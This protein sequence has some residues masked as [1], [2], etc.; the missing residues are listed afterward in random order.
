MTDFRFVQNGALWL[1]H[2]LDEDISDRYAQ[3]EPFYEGV[4][5]ARFLNVIDRK[6]YTHEFIAEVEASTGETPLKL[7]IEAIDHYLLHEFNTIV[8]AEWK[9][10]PEEIPVV[11]SSAA[12]L[13]TMVMYMTMKHHKVSAKLAD[14][15]ADKSD[16]EVLMQH[17]QELEGFVIRLD[18]KQK[19]AVL[20]LPAS[21]FV[22]NSEDKEN[23]KATF[24][25]QFALKAE[26]AQLEDKIKALEAEVTQQNDE[27]SDLKSRLHHFETQNSQASMLTPLTTAH[28]DAIANRLEAANR[29]KEK[30]EENLVAKSKELTTLT[31]DYSELESKYNEAN[32]KLKT[33]QESL[34]AAKEESQKL[35]EDL[36]ATRSQV[37]DFN[38]DRER[39]KSLVEA[40]EERTEYL[41]KLEREKAELE[42]KVGELN[43][44]IDEYHDVYA[45]NEQLREELQHYPLSEP[46]SS[47]ASFGNIMPLCDDMM[48]DVAS[49]NGQYVSIAQYEARVMQL[50]HEVQVLNVKLEETKLAHQKVLNQI[51]AATADQI[52]ELNETILKLK[53][54]LA[55][56]YEQMRQFKCQTVGLRTKLHN[57]TSFLGQLVMFMTFM[58]FCFLMYLKLT[59]TPLFS[60]RESMVAHLK[61]FDDATRYFGRR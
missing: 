50:S 9:P 31:S 51:R 21:T 16:A 45:E 13:V 2:V 49:D 6:R 56:C 17:V 35:V 37:K 48:S 22:V 33:L 20:T 47:E 59:N 46:S 61:A 34:K 36:E 26:R 30:L 39:F 3:L 27:V 12:K 11:L 19:A 60:S 4:L 40:L 41:E 28:A 10:H 42:G 44:R 29:C 24:S 43:S 38:A 1:A 25:D 5:L 53:D 18:A 7:I 55:K 14:I 58:L 15:F 57:L 8:S 32:D 23:E 52:N 54:E